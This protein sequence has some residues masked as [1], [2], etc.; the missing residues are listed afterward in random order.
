MTA[1]VYVDEITDPVTGE[2]VTFR[3]S[4]VAEL[5]T[6]VEERFGITREDREAGSADPSLFG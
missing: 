6:M 4:S 3:A 1:R 5:E 2:V